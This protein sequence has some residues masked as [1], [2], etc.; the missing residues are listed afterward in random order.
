MAAAGVAGR[1][2]RGWR[3]R[4][5]VVPDNSGH[6]RQSKGPRRV[7]SAAHL[8]WSAPP[9]P[10]VAG[11]QAGRR[12]KWVSKT[13]HPVAQKP[14]L[15]SPGR[16]HFPRLLAQPLPCPAGDS[17]PSCS[18]H[19]SCN[20]QRNSQRMVVLPALSRPSTR[21]RASLSPK[22]LISFENHSPCTQSQQQ[23][24]GCGQPGSKKRPHR[25]RARQQAGRLAAPAPPTLATHR[26]LRSAPERLHSTAGYAACVRT[27]QA[28]SK[29]SLALPQTDLEAGTRYW[30]LI[31]SRSSRTPHI[32]RQTAQ[33]SPF[34]ANKGLGE[35]VLG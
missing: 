5:S 32:R 11:L 23:G 9:P 18:C 13:Q 25:G 3:E 7:C 14:P 30:G 16:R 8:G 20:T 24:S 33:R 27:L 22:R 29:R 4:W 34:A 35:W 28:R 21:M 26:R 19:E 17:I 2:G 31:A 10:R 15:A 12:R 1:H 6:W